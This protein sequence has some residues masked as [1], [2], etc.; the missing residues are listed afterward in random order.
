MERQTRLDREARE[1]VRR[2]DKER[3]VRVAV[4]VP[5]RPVAACGT[6]SGYRRHQRLKE[7][8]C[9]PCREAFR[10]YSRRLAA[11]RAIAHQVERSAAGLGKGQWSKGTAPCGT[12]AARRRHRRRGEECAVC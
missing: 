2:E 3:D 1:R 11:Q 6:R 4:V 9:G 12:R 8:V 7:A 10:A 5:G